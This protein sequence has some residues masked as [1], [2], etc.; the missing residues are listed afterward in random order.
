MWMIEFHD[1]RLGSSL[2]FMHGLCCSIPLLLSFTYTFQ[3]PSFAFQGTSTSPIECQLCMDE[4]GLKKTDLFLKI[5]DVLDSVA[6]LFV[7]WFRRFRR[8][9][10]GS[11]AFG[12]T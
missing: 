1:R 4:S 3:Q 7:C 6:V 10:N 12:W 11:L 5:V 2:C 8:F 9:R